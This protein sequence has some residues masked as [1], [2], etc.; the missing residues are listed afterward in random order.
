MRRTQ[1]NGISKQFYVY[2]PKPKGKQLQYN[3]FGRRRRTAN[4]EG[5]V[6]VRGKAGLTRVVT[7]NIQTRTLA[8]IKQDEGNVCRFSKV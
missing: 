1:M 6:V 5:R 3:N 4:G 8:L 7:S 2:C